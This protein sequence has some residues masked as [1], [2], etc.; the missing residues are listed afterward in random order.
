[1][2]VVRKKGNCSLT[3]LPESEIYFVLNSQHSQYRMSDLW[4][5]NNTKTWQILGRGVQSTEPDSNISNAL[6]SSR[7]L[8]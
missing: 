7:V 8:F 5:L 1:M 2:S 4:K 6:K 3:L